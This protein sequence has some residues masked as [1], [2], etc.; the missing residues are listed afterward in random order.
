MSQDFH[1]GF[2]TPDVGSIVVGAGHGYD[3][4]ARRVGGRRGLHD[5]HR[6]ASDSVVRLLVHHDDVA[7][8]ITTVVHD[9]HATV[10]QRRW[11]HFVVDYGHHV[12]ANGFGHGAQLRRVTAV[13]VAVDH[14][15]RAHHHRGGRRVHQVTA[16]PQR[17]G[18]RP[19]TW[20][21]AVV[22]RLVMTDHRRR[23]VQV[24]LA[25]FAATTDV[26]TS[27]NHTENVTIKLELRK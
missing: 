26:L 20:R 2:P 9:H 19:V 4:R 3:D 10:V 27:A 21:A 14:G 13:I 16:R 24:Q 17:A 11:R 18:P 25:G 1:F 6:T 23:L 8:V 12:T 22:G 5:G 15:R 7:H